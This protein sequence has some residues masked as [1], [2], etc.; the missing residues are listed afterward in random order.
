MAAEGASVFVAFWQNETFEVAMV[1]LNEDSSS[2][3]VASTIN[4]RIK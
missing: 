4:G 1:T 3:R 2:G